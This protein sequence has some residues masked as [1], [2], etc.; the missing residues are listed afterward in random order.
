MTQVTLAARTF[1]R[2]PQQ[3]RVDAKGNWSVLMF[4]WFPGNTGTPS[5]RWEPIER[6]RVPDE[7][8]EAAK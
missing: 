4:G 5:Y 1:N 7:L 3:W 2:G 8:I 6:S